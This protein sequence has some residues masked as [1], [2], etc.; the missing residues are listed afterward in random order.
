[1]EK[2]IAAV[3]LGT[4]KITVLAGEKTSS[5]KF[6]ILAHHEAPSRGVVHGKVLNNV[7]VGNVL[8]SLVDGLK[9]QAGIN[10]T[11]VYVGISGKHIQCNSK[12]SRIMRD[13]PAVEISEEEIHRLK[14]DMYNI[15]VES[16]NRVLDVIPQVYHLD[17]GHSEPN[18]VGICSYLL[19][20]EFS[21]LIGAE[22]PMEL[23]QRSI[24]RAGLHLKGLFLSPLAAAEAV[25]SDDDK[26]MGVAV[27]DIGG[28]T[29]SV[30]VYYDD[31]VRH[32]AV[33][34]F[35]SDVVTDDICQGCAI[36]LRYAER[37]KVQYGSCYSDLIRENP[38][39]RIS[40]AG[41]AEVSFRMLTKI[42]EARMAEIIEAV[43]YEI[44]Q[45]GYADRLSAGIVL[46]GGGAR[47]GELTEF[48]KYKTGMKARK[49]EPLF[50]TSDSD[51]DVQHGDYATAVGL[52]MKGAIENGYTIMEK[53]PVVVE[54]ELFEWKP[55][56]LKDTKK[57]TKKG[58][59]HNE[60]EIK[61]PNSFSKFTGDLFGKFF[62]PNDNGI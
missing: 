33:I 62:T 18:P 55:V 26:N 15:H 46:T 32:V 34:P 51:S 25:L 52:L 50:V 47:L 14:C 42:I 31:I 17:D 57:G 45:S 37:L 41:D 16:G 49:G 58:T 1:M 9:Q 29:T 12:K 21:V 24:Q 43:E 40:G 6:H 7:E 3:D 44:Q 39:F 54:P 5:G 2:Y 61:K 60:S 53:T 48:V 4:K 36:P 56:G 10:V 27:V 28:G 59:K 35:G 30:A 19:E 11:E 22:K 23:I 8:K 13:D 20:A 38:T